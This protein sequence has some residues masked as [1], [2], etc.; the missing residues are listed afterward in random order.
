MSASKTLYATKDFR[1]AGTGRTFVAGKPIEKVTDGELGNYEA[2]GL[3]GDK[4]TE[5][6]AKPA[7]GKNA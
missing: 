4:P 1:D 3:A 6:P 5:A 7:D 2:A